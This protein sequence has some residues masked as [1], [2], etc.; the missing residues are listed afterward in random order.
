ME[1]TALNLRFGFRLIFGQLFDYVRDFE[2]DHLFCVERDRA[3]H[4]LEVA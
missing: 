1:D 4:P 2:H 3:I